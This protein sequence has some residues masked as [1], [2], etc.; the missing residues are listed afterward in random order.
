[1]TYRDVFKRASALVR[2]KAARQC[3]QIEATQVDDLDRP[4]LGGAILAHTPYFTVS[5]DKTNGWVIDG[6]VVHGIPA[7]TGS[8]TTVLALFTASADMH[9]LDN[10]QS[11]IGEARVTQRMPTR[12][13][14]ALSLTNGKPDPHLTYKAVI[15]VLPLAPLGIQISGEESGITLVKK[16]L[17]TTGP[18]G[19]A[20]LLVKE[21]A[22]APDLRLLAQTNGYRIMRAADDRPLVIDV[23]GIK[24]GRAHV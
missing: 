12:S 13:K 24:I 1:M 3:P 22:S 18:G 19:T 23:A 2:A 17:A 6:G 15:T 8:E 5:F 16:V 11:A 4:F 10:L 9:Q 14:V 21:T 20:S 7:A